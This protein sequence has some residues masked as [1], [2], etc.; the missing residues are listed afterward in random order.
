MNTSRLITR[1]TVATGAV[2]AVPAIAVGAA[3]PAMASSPPPPPVVTFTGAGCKLP[4]KSTDYP[5]GYRLTFTVTATAVDVITFL[6]VT[7]PG[8]AGELIAPTEAVALLPGDNEVEVTI[9]ASNSANGTATIT[10]SSSGG[11]G[12]A[13]AEIT[14]FRP[15]K[16]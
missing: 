9:G 16:D 12:V 5:W 3:A 7:A 10:W 1:R 6:T 2:W 11:A 13:T 4:G 8:G 14:G 15:C